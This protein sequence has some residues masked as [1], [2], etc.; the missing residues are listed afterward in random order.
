[1]V[2]VLPEGSTG[3]VVVP[4]GGFVPT[5][6]PLIWVSPAPDADD[7]VGPN[8]ST[9]SHWVTP[10]PCSKTPDSASCS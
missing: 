6:T 5:A 10:A 4:L 3:Y 9:R 7:P 8:S 1:M 2:E